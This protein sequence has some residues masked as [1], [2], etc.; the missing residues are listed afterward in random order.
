[1]H[2]FKKLKFSATIIVSLLFST[3][4]QA[5]LI[6]GIN[7]SLKSDGT[8]SVIAGS[9]NTS[10]ALIIPSAVL[11]W[12]SST[13]YDVYYVTSISSYAF[14]NC[15]NL[16]AI[17]IPYTIESIGSYA[18]SNCT[19][20]MTFTN[21]S[22]LITTISSCTFAN[23]TS[24]NYFTIPGTITKIGDGAFSGCSSLQSIV[25][26]NSVTSIGEY[27]FAGC[28]Q[29]SSFSIPRSVISISGNV[30]SGCSGL[31]SITVTSDNPT[32]DSRDNCNAIIHKSSNRL[33]SGCK[34]TII[35][36]TVTT[37]GDESFYGCRGLTSV[38]IPSSVTTIGYEAFD[39]CSSLA[40]VTCMATNPPI[41]SEY[42]SFSSSVYKNAS[43]HV[44]A[45]SVQSYK[46]A[47]YWKNFV[48]IIGDADGNPDPPTNSK[49][50]V[51]GDGEVTIADVNMVIDAILGN[52]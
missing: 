10:G 20:L 31:T 32:Y 52:N 37:I 7:Y 16:T 51:N 21:Y 6:E 48:T 50:D 26:P 29:L 18:F 46:T 14:E 15:R 8:A 36:N 1:M 23:C 44:P 35:P 42:S 12:T 13:T 33:I 9:T 34:T 49:C 25:I 43:L 30:I 19:S 39:L 41:I 5:T 3:G 2:T 27:A 47:N 22:S 40:N 28:T 38:N 17:T 45:N 11:H 4:A 24:L